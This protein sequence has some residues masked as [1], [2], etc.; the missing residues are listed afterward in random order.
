[1]SRRPSTSQSS[2]GRHASDLGYGRPPAQ[3]R[4]KPG[5]IGNPKGRPRGRKNEATIWHDRLYRTITISE[6]GTMHKIT[7]LEG[8]L[9]RFIES[10]LKGDIKSA[11]FILSRLH[12]LE[13][14]ESPADH[15]SDDDRKVLEA[16]AEI[17]LAQSKKSR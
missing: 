17:I 6:N 12:G 14:G 8:I 7:V 2:G 16:Y 4:F 1:M 5:Q 9:L 13:S 15:F 11:A 3:H 10:A